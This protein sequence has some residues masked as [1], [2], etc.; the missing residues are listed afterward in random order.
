[1]HEKIAAPLSAV[2]YNN[3]SMKSRLE[4]KLDINEL[5]E[6][7]CEQDIILRKINID[8]Q[9]NEDF[10]LLESGL[11]KRNDAIFNPDR[12]VKEI[13]KLFKWNLDMK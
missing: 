8:L 13:I 2:Y 4:D 10:I 6:S 11:L 12:N 3:M 5:Q 9:T 7:I 1:M